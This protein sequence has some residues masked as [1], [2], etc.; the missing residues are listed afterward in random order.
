MILEED[1][2]R[3]ICQVMP[4]P[5]VDLIVEDALDRVLL[6]KRK[7]EPAKGEWWFPG[8]R[9]NHGE[10]RVEAAHRKLNE[11]CG[12]IAKNISVLYTLEILFDN[13]VPSFHALTTIIIM[14]IEKNKIIL[15]SQSSEGKWQS[16]K[17]WEL[18][19]LHPLLKTI[20]K[21]VHTD[22]A[23]A[24]TPENLQGLLRYSSFS[25]K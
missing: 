19:P 10:S 7:N 4:I 17:E 21:S 11:E 16:F 13:C 12:M 14:V 5:C 3:Q 25:I 23:A 20:I 24:I 6:L 1:F 22:R 2:Y 9:I 18:S 8:G 15:D